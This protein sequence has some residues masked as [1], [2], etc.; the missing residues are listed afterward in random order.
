MWTYDTPAPITNVIDIPAG[1]VRFVATDRADTTVE[2]LPDDTAKSRD[3][4]AAEQCRVSYGE[5]VLRIGAPSAKTRHIGPSGSVEVIVRLPEGSHVEVKAA[6][7][8]F[9]ATGRLGDIAVDGA[10]GAIEIDEAAS[11]RLSAL[12]GDVV[13]GHLGGSAEIDTHKGDIRIAE[14]VSGTVVLRT[15]MGDVSVHAA[16]GVSASLDAGTGHGRIDNTLK[17]TGGTTD[18]NIH[19]TT[20]LGT[21]TARSL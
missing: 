11:V 2:V 8:E 9:R 20:E 6:C 12:A 21:I 10:N 5:G 19:A 4:K 13:V 1:R 16:A 18:L 15:R 3:V 7:V 14:A 17:H